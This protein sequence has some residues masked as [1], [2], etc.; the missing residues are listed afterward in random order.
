MNFF[1]PKWY[2]DELTDEEVIATLVA[3]D[4]HLESLEGRVQAEVISLAKMYGVKDGLIIEV[5]EESEKHHL[6]L[7]MLCGDIQIGYFDL[8]I[9]YEGASISPMDRWVLARIAHLTEN[10]RGNIDLAQ[11]ELD[12]MDDGRIEHS[13]L[14]HPGRC[15]VI[16][17]KRLTYTVTNQPDRTLPNR[18]DR[19]PGGPKAP[20]YRHTRSLIKPVSR[21]RY[22]HRAY[23]RKYAG[24]NVPRPN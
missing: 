18:T 8:T 15:F 10:R 11:H 22:V 1:T 13:F 9:R 7:T 14:F 24:C 16:Q 20:P 5:V 2:R 4:K 19:F 3:Y 17:S 12:L 23:L 21:F 6:T